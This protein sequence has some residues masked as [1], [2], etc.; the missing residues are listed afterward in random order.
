MFPFEHEGKS[1]KDVHDTLKESLWQPVPVKNMGNFQRQARPGQR[2]R[3]F[4]ENDVYT[5]QPVTRDGKLTGVR[6]VAHGLYDFAIRW[7]EQNKIYCGLESVISGH[8]AISLGS[9]VAYAGDMLIMNGKLKHWTN[10]SGHYMPPSGRHL[11]NICPELR[12]IL[13]KKLFSNY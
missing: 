7:K 1:F 5:V 3:L 8:T 2:F 11:T 6:E 13:P 9:D 4:K 10:N 12:D